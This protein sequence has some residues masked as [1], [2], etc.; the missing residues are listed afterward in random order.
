[1]SVSGN[2]LTNALTESGVCDMMT[3]IEV[4]IFSM[5]ELAISAFK[6]ILTRHVLSSIA[7]IFSTLLM[8]QAKITSS[9]KHYLLKCDFERRAFE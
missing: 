9:K 8:D 2:C 6:G 5:P 4:K 1:M 3:G 7:I